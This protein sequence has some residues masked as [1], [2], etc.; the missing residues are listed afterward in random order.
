MNSVGSPTRRL[1]LDK[2]LADYR[3]SQLFVWPGLVWGR[4]TRILFV[5]LR[6]I[7]L[8][9]FRERR[10]VYRSLPSSKYQRAR[11]EI[12]RKKRSEPPGERYEGDRVAYKGSL[13]TPGALILSAFEPLR[14]KTRTHTHTHDKKN[15]NNS[16]V[17][18]IGRESGDSPFVSG[19]R[20]VRNCG[21]FNKEMTRDIRATQ[22]KRASNK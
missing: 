18:R 7:H 3:E 9:I 12:I 16:V 19:E 4:L 20:T 21:T 6:F 2:I 14:E 15:K 1:A 22:Y 11:E 8:F 5:R 10:D 13:T 17:R